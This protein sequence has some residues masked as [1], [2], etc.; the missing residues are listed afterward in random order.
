MPRWPDKELNAAEQ[1]LGK[2]KTLVIPSAGEII[3]NDQELE[4]SDKPMSANEFDELSFMEEKVEVMVHESTDPNAENPVHLGC[5]G[6]NQYVLR[7][8]PIV[9][10]RKFVEILARA[11]Q[12]AMKTA[13]VRGYDGE[14][15][16]QVQKSSAL[17]YPFSII[18][19]ENP[20]GAAWL[21]GVLSEG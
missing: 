12:T 11:K 9:V 7:G 3:R 14:L 18:R 8:Q 2:Q 5:N 10:R 20:K 15:Q 4:V 19:D 1:D 21:R 17:R 13:E 6:V 16:T